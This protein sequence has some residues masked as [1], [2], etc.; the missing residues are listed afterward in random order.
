MARI[1]LWTM[2]EHQTNAKRRLLMITHRLMLGALTLAAN[3]YAGVVLAE[4]I[5]MNNLVTGER[6]D[7]NAF[8]LVTRGRLESKFPVWKLWG[9]WG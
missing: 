7:N 1:N 8:V 6:D 5:N 3:I 2:A 4:K 9:S